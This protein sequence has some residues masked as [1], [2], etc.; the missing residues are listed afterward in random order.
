[1]VVKSFEFESHLWRGVLDTT[2]WDKVCHGLAE[3]LQCSTNK[4]DCNNMTE[5]LLKVALNTITNPNNS[6]KNTTN[7]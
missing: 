6:L 2:L 1:M 4:T 3:G 5:I 7:I